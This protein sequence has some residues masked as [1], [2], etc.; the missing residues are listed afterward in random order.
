MDDVKGLGGRN[1]AKIL[2][3]E[4]R[5][6]DIGCEGTGITW[7]ILSAPFRSPTTINKTFMDPGSSD[8]RS[9]SSFPI[10]GG[11]VRRGGKQGGF[12]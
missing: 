5:V 7:R 12:E 4:K 9:A 10:V 6:K 11:R 2:G 1:G 3:V 8:S